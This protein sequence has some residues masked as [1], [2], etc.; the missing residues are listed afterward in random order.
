[1]R[2][3]LSV[4]VMKL[5]SELHMSVEHFTLLRKRIEQETAEAIGGGMK[6]IIA[7]NKAGL[8]QM[9]EGFQ[10]QIGVA[11]AGVSAS[12]AETQAT[13]AKS[14]EVSARLLTAIEQLSER[15]ERSQ[16]PA[17]VI[18]KDLEELALTVRKAITAENKRL[19][20]HRLAVESLLETHKEIVGQARASVDTL[21]AGKAAS[22]ALAAGIRESTD[23]LGAMLG[24]LK[25]ISEVS[26]QAEV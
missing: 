17:D 5:Q 19:E 15:I 10:T 22:E 3:S 18:R 25:G 13:A 8:S 9:V 6:Q 7:D 1:M 20:S 24:H 26:G 14:R 11:L 2:E 21:E 12:I 23:A 16:S 4:A